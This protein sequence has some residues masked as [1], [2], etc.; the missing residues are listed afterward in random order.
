MIAGTFYAVCT[1]A[2]YRWTRRQVPARN[3][4]GRWLVAG[5]GAAFVSLLAWGVVAL[6]R[7]L[8]E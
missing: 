8:V 7:F 1:L 2:I 5:I 6:G 3:Y 4:L